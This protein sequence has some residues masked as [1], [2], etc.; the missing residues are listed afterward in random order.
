MSFKQ[1]NE[2]PFAITPERV[3]VFGVSLFLVITISYLFMRVI[4]FFFTPEI[5]VKNPSGVSRKESIAIE[6]RVVSAS[7]LTLNGEVVYIGEN[8][9]FSKDAHLYEG[10]NQIILKA[11]NWLGRSAEVVGRVVYISK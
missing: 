11:H 1:Q 6:G 9:F 5:L 8:G 2:F 10:V 4:P 3:A 7:R